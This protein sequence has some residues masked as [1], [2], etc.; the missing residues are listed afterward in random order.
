MIKTIANLKK[1]SSEK[2]R[3]TLNLYINNIFQST[4]MYI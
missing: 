3:T 1:W 4:Q 2:N